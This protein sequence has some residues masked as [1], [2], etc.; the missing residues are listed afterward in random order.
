MTTTPAHTPAPAA[1]AAVGTPDT[2]ALSMPRTRAGVAIGTHTIVDFFSFIIVPL[3]PLLGTR[4]DLTSGQIAVALAV[5]SVCSGVIQPIVAWLSDR[6][7]TRVLG[8]LGFLVAVLAIGMIGHAQTYTHLLLIQALGTAGIGAFHPPAAAAVGQLAGQRRSLAVA[9]FFMAG[10]AGGM[11]GNAFT[12]LYVEQFGLRAITW[13]IP[14]GLLS[15]VILA[16]AIHRVPHRALNAREMHNAQSPRDRRRRWNAVG[17]LFACNALRFTTNMALIYLYIEWIT[18]FAA[19]RAGQATIDETI[20]LRASLLN[21]PLQASMQLGM[22]GGG[23]LLGWWLARRYEKPYLIA[24]PFIGAAIVA[25]FPHL[26]LLVETPFAWAILPAA[27]ALAVAGGVGFGG[28]IPVSIAL[29]QRLLPHRTSLASGLMLGGAWSLAF[30]GPILA[31]RIHSTFGFVP[32]FT[33]VAGLL[34]LAGV[35]AIAIPGDLL[36]ATAR[37]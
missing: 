29:A 1:T 7:D 2:P 32:A 11:A 13:F 36:R 12:P 22:G 18:A 31:E 8:T 14:F 20:G 9:V 4:L 5:G 37:W 17:L 23:I 21:G 10:M 27:F 35:L 34:T 19:S 25:V 30:I 28:L 24:V 6:W 16:L 3:M 15:V 33:A 26:D